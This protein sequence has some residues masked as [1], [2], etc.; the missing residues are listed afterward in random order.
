MNHDRPALRVS[1]NHKRLLAEELQRSRPATANPAATLRQ[2]FL[3]GVQQRLVEI[4]IR[5][6]SSGD[7]RPAVRAINNLITVCRADL[8]A[9]DLEPWLIRHFDFRLNPLT[10]AFE[11]GIKKASGLQLADLRSSKWWSGV[12]DSPTFRPGMS[13]R[14][15]RDAD[16]AEI[17]RDLIQIA[18][19]WIETG[20]IRPAAA[21]VNRLARSFPKLTGE[22]H[23]FASWLKTHF[24]FEKGADGDG[25]Q[26]GSF[27]ARDL[28]FGALSAQKWWQSIRPT[29]VP[30]AELGSLE[31]QPGPRLP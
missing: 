4:A 29:R 13:N 21:S 24:N 10:G 3:D 23:A 15:Q 22:S 5:W 11:S 8:A 2:E 9:K 19:R 7:A 16:R 6:K 30:P 26:S 18:R 12:D 14:R 28:R 25:F 1:D 20:D 17:Q 27:K 31:D